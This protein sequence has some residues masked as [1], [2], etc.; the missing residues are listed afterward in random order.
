MST[1]MTT[2][3]SS[4]LAASTMEKVLVGGDLSSLT[5]TERMQVYSRTC[6]SLGLNPLT[7]PFDYL[8]LNGGVKLYAKREATDQLRKLNGVSIV[9][10]TAVETGGVYIVTITATDAAGRMD[11]DMGAVAIEGLQGEARSNAMMKALTKAK[12]R[13]TLSICGLGWLDESEIESIPNAQRVVVDTTTGV[14]EGHVVDAPARPA[15]VPA[16]AP[17][18]DT[19]DARIAANKS[20]HAAMSGAGIDTRD[21]EYV[22][23]LAG[24]LLG[25][26]TS[27]ASLRALTVDDLRTVAARLNQATADQMDEL[28]AAY[29]TPVAVEDD[30]PFDG[31]D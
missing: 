27:P 23:W 2:M 11:T 22:R 16:P 24:R 12:R 28:R 5:P 4:D 30:D 31:L 13:V 29:S 17:A 8:K 14:I 9:S 3:A 25:T 21:R 19:E 1:A 15:P 7:K 18:G 20:L 6:E 26:A 10:H